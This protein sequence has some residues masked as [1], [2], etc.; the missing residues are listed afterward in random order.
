MLKERTTLPKFKP[1]EL[2]KVIDSTHDDRM[3][4]HRTGLVLE[5]IPTSKS[6]TKI[7][8]ILFVGTEIELKFHEMFLERIDTNLT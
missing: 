4:S 1:G 3:P 8:T 7:Y 6:Y 2:V 5:E